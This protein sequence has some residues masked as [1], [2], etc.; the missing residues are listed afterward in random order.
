LARVSV[1]RGLAL[2]P[3]GSMKSIRCTISAP[4]PAL[5]IA[6]HS[7]HEST[8]SRALL[9]PITIFIVSGVPVLISHRATKSHRG[10]DFILINVTIRPSKLPNKV[11][12]WHIVVCQEFFTRIM[13]E[14]QIL[15]NIYMD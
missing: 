11:T 8:C 1:E 10:R 6:G 13:I 3:S 2:K 12:P 4:H 7:M 15:N 9:I 14:K 5:D